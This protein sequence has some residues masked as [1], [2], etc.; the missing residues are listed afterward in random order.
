MRGEI[1]KKLPGNILVFLISLIVA[2][3]LAEVVVRIYFSSV[4]QAII[5]KNRHNILTRAPLDEI[6]AE[7]EYGGYANKPNHTVRWWGLNISTDSLG[8][9]VGPE[10]EES[11]LV[12]LFLGDSMVFGVGLADSATVPAVLQEE[13]QNRSPSNPCRVVNGGVIGYDFEQYLHHFRRLSA[14]IKPDLVLVGICHNDLF[15]T[16]DPFKNI[17]NEWDSRENRT[18][19]PAAGDETLRWLA[20]GI[21]D[22]LRSSSLYRLWR[23]VTI[24]TLRSRAQK[25]VYSPL[26][27]KSIQKAPDLV[28]EFI[29]EL[30]RYGV[31]YAFVYFP[32]YLHLR[33]EKA[34]KILYVELLR[35]RNLSVLDLS[36]NPDLS[37]ESYFMKE[38]QGQLWPEMH[39]NPAGAS[40][41]GRAIADWLIEEGLWN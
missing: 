4:E 12:I 31:P 24:E 6:F 11:D 33:N 32:A 3:F 14:R 29:D 23:K 1:R 19:K 40:I 2:L 34:E 15:P 39:F 37:I 17:I 20:R 28:D 35:E 9:R 27:Q 10:L 26:A 5:A 13:L 30:N 18:Q 16:E 8:C 22:W 7:V 21:R 38:V 25:Q 41:V 36:W